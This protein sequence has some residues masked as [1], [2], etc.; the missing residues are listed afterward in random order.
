M[1]KRRTRRP[2][3]RGGCLFTLIE[4]LG[5]IIAG[6]YVISWLTGIGSAMK[7]ETVH[8]EYDP[9][10]FHTD[11]LLHI[12]WPN[13]EDYSRAVA[14][15]AAENRTYKWGAVYVN[16]DGNKDVGLMQISLDQQKKRL[17]QMHISEWML[18]FAPV[19][20]W[21]AKDIWEENGR[22][23]RGQ[24]HGPDNCGMVFP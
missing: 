11:M 1:A 7:Y 4:I 21:V 15:V 12:Y 8:C 23:F 22:S 5:V 20:L 10:P 19:N 9:P 16:T 18:Y 24:W 6:G 17:K 3:P 2:T 14:T 13:P